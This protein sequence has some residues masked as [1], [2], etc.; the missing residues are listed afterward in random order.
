MHTLGIDVGGSGIK[1]A[2][3]DLETGELVTERLRI[4]TPPS[5]DIDSVTQAIA[6]LVR[7]F[8][9]QGPVGVGFPAAVADGV[10]LTAPTAHEVSGWVGES[11]TDCFSNATGCDVTVLNDAD[12]AGLAE[13]RFGAGQGVSGVVITVTLGTGIGGGLFMDGTLVPNLEIG[14]IYL[15][16]QQEVAEQYV[17]SRIKTEQKLSWKTYGKRL[18]EFCLLVEHVFS[19]QLIIIGGGIS[20]KHEKFLPGVSLKRTPVVPAEAFNEAGI[21]GAAVWSG[22][23]QD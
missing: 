2:L 4:K 21:T 6:R 1:G 3:V 20:Q 13:M 19:P 22:V 11:V 18:N 5:F 16:G 17:A 12:A 9:Y 23:M 7:K 10:A 14:K 15:K 8:D